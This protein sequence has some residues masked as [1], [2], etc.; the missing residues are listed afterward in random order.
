MGVCICVSMCA[1]KSATRFQMDWQKSIYV[2]VYMCVYIYIYTCVCVY[3]EGGRERE[4]KQMWQMLGTG[5]TKRRLYGSFLSSSFIEMKL[6]F[7]TQFS[8][9]YAEH[10]VL[11]TYIVK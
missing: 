1:F 11:I 7:S 6:T 3:W 5:K 8:L 9:K 4:R 2:C 10:N